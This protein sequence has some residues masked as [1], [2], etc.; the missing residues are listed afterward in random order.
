MTDEERSAR[1]LREIF[2]AGFMSGL[3]PENVAWAASRLARAMEDVRL[4]AG[5]VLYRAGALANS[6]YFVVE[7]EVRLEAP[8][9][10]P[11]T[12]GARSLVGTLD[13]TLDRPRSRTVIATRD[14]HLLRVPAGDWLDLL[15]DNF[16]LTRG[17]VE[18]LATG[19]HTVRLELDELGLDEEPPRS[20]RSADAPL[21]RL[22][23]VERI[24]VLRGVPLFEKADVQSLTS[25]AELAREVDIAKGDAVFPNGVSNESMFV[26]VSGSVTAS[27][28]AVA[29]HAT[30]GPGMLVLGST[31]VSANDLGYDVRA[32]TATRAL[33]IGHEDCFDVMEEH[34]LLARSAMK[35]LAA[36][37]EQLMNERGERKA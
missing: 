5:D 35:A 27:R 29:R 34:F 18:G 2:L 37:R 19:V 15:E 3:P 33:R 26:I 4:R 12:L 25:L 32:D 1:L 28:G 21:R 22:D 7:G 16:D 14:T 6:H 36:E 31:A 20:I 8:G 9:A 17:G 13:V 11:W 30:F 24:F 10:P 23:L